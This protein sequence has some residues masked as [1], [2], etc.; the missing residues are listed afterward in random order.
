MYRHIETK[1]GHLPPSFAS[2]VQLCSLTCVFAVVNTVSAQ[3]LWTAGTGDWNTAS[4]WTL[5]VP[6]A[7]S[8]TAFDAVIENGGTAQLTGPP[9]GSVRRLRIGRTAGGGNLVVDAATLTVTENLHLNETSSAPAS[10]T[11]Q[12]GATVSSPSTVVGYTSN[13]NTNFI[14]SGAGTTFNAATQF[15]VGNLGAGT[16]SL[17][18]DD[19]GVLTSGTGWVGNGTGATGVAAVRNPGSRWSTAT[20]LTV[21]N[22]GTGT[23][24]IEDQGVVFVGTTL[25]INGT[26]NVNLD[27][28]TLR[29]DTVAG[30]NRLNYTAGTIQ[31]AGSR[32]LS[33]DTTI[34]TIFGPSPTIPT[35]KELVI[36]GTANLT[37]NFASFTVD[38]GRFSSASYFADSVAAGALVIANGGVVTTTGSA[39]VGI[40]NNNGGVANLSGAGSTWNVGNDLIVGP[41]SGGLSRIFVSDGALLYVGDTLQLN[42]NGDIILE[43][44][45]I[46]FADIVNYTKIDWRFGTIQLAG[47]QFIADT[48]FASQFLDSGSRINVGKGL[49][50]EGVA[51]MLTLVTVDGGTF[52]AGQIVNPSLLDLQRGTFNLTNQ[53]VTI[54]T[55]GLL[56]NALDVK[57]DTTINVTLGIINEGLVTGDGQLGGSFANVAGGELRAE[58]GRSLTLTGTGNTNAGQIRL[59]GGALDFRA[60]LTNEATGLISGNGSLLTAGLVNDGTMSFAGT[61]NIL[62]SVTNSATGR[63]ISG[64]G[65][66]TVFYDDVVNNGE[67]RTSTNGFTVFFGGVSGS[68][69][70]T[71]TGTVNFEGDLNPGS[72]P[73]TVDFAGDVAFGVDAILNM[74]IGGATPGTQYDQLVVQGNLSLDGELSVSTLPGFT[75][76]AG[77]SFN[78]LD[79]FGTR[80]GTFSSLTL[81][82]LAGLTWNTSQ[83]YTTGVLSLIN[84]AG[85]AGDY[86]QD[87]RVNAADYT[88][89]RNNLGSGTA[90]PN[91]DTPGVGP[92]DYTRWKMHFGESSGSGAG[93]TGFASAY[94]TVPEPASLALLLVAGAWLILTGYR[95]PAFAFGDSCIEFGDYE[96]CRD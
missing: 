90:L 29:F 30:L 49:T 28:G 15:I 91:D 88:V 31:L 70:F 84:A 61:A 4:N 12:N 14:I 45:T 18:V 74:E 79:W 65:G 56:G 80:S 6:N 53:A 86:N 95:R 44:G 96:P 35:G 23:L 47:N 26:S 9:N 68:G 11:V 3:T 17:T 25:A 24:A 64:G 54:G 94:V 8:G 34:T 67:I 38:G 51:T 73:A 85:L 2:V 32:N 48:G 82:T 81:P 72:S 42:N 37:Q 66:A 63:I 60:D 5:G 13:S 16:A 93:A 36:E 92:D 27:G 78:I 62:G 77:Q 58:P 87:G 83:L 71:G 89:W 41:N 21:G 43:G 40:N 20:T 7:A 22:I 50:V 52:S 19:G 46:R 75:P 33:T 1:P 10:V 59:L 76:A 57:K 55:G 39:T 69:S